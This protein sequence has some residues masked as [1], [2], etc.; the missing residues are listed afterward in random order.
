MQLE[1]LQKLL[2]KEPAYRLKQIKQALFCDLVDDWESATVLP[3]GLRRKLAEGF[4]LKIEADAFLSKDEAAVK[5]L[6]HLS[7]GL[8]VESVLMRHNDR[9]TV[10]VSSQVGCALGCAFCATGRFGFKRNL[11][12]GEIVEQVLFWARYLKQDH[13]KLTNI[14]FMGMGEPFLNYDNVL[15]AIKILNDPEGF[16]LGARHFSISTAGV[17]E[18][19]NKLAAEPLQV[20][21]AISLH[22]PNDELRERLMPVNK[23]YPINEIL[24]AVDHY[25]GMNRRRV[26]FEYIMIKDVNDS[27]REAAELARIVRGRLCFVNLISYNPTSI[28]EPSP[29]GR[30]KEFKK[31]LEKEGVAV[32]QRWRLGSDIDAACG[33][34]AGF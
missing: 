17:I 16:N 23:K 20:N 9:R 19:I 27:P 25:I 18:G 32:T 10:C 30:T 33:Q 11:E 21:L 22:A 1:N 24:K 29:A 5:I 3:A 12:A 15:S 31:I 14:V 28:F 8:K 7:D 34:L 26:M 4:P 2:A 13:Q 6:L